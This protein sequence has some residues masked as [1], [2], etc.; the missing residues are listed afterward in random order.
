MQLKDRV[1][2]VASTGRHC[3]NWKDDQE[4]V[5]NLLNKIPLSD[6]GADGVLRKPERFVNG[7]I[8]DNIYSAILYFQKHNFPGNV[9]DGNIRPGGP[10][11]KALVA[12]S[13]RAAAKPPANPG[14][15]TQ[16]ATPSVY[17]SLTKGLSDRTLDHSEVFDIVRATLADGMITAHEVDDLNFIVSNGKSLEPRSKRLLT[18]VTDEV[19]FSSVGNGPYNFDSEQKRM[20]VETV[21]DF[22]MKNGRT[23]FPK[24]SRQHVGIGMLLR[25]GNPGMIRQGAA[26]LCG[27][28]AMMFNY[29]SDWPVAYV[30]FAI[31]MYE[32]GKANL[33]RLLIKPGSD[34]RDYTPPRSISPV[35]WLTMASIRDSENWFL[36]FDDTGR[37]SDMAGITLPSEMEQWMRKAGYSDVRENTNLTNMMHKGIGTVDAANALY[38]KGYRVCLFISAN[39]AEDMTQS[40]KSLTD[41]KDMGE[42]DQSR[43]GSIMTRHWVVQRSLI[44]KS[45]GNIKLKIFTWGNGDYSIPV[46]SRNLPAEH[47][48]MNFYGYVAGKA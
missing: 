13:A 7:N 31:D 5:F 9:P 27:P 10:T 1:G 21:R 8:N 35:D 28:A 43:R 33:G 23:Y 37:I 32:K 46:G 22:L 45:G 48:L 4:L 29:A 47:F 11:F 40:G 18:A 42:D 20:A 14:Q 3:Q 25:I 30:R 44:D 26:S 19:Y 34:V 38:Q 16:I 2:R 6:G 17:N 12:L 41:W 24:L 39:M 36:D 15:W